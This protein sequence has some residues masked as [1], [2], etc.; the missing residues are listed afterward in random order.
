METRFGA[1]GRDAA[2]RAGGRWVAT[3]RPWR[4]YLCFLQ[5]I[6]LL[7]AGPVSP[8][9]AQDTLPQPLRSAREALDSGRIQEAIR[10]SERYTWGHPRDPRGFVLLGDAWFANLPVGRFRAAQAYQEAERLA[11]RDPEPP[12]KYASVG[13]WLGGDDGEGMAKRGLERVLEIA[14]LYRDAWDLWLMLFRSEGSR[15]RMR[16]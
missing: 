6:V 1:G 10:L 14:P 8:A 3:R 12:Y 5:W 9:S 13:L 7:G 2:T 16:Q 4:R 11:P 15:R